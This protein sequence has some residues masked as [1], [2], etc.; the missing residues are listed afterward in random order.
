[1]RICDRKNRIRLLRT[2]V[3]LGWPFTHV[4][5]VWL[6]MAYSVSDKFDNRLADKRRRHLYTHT[7]KIC[8]ATAPYQLACFILLLGRVY[9]RPDDWKRIKR[10]QNTWFRFDLVRFS[11]FRFFF[12]IVHRKEGT[13]KQNTP[14]FPFVLWAFYCS[15]VQTYSTIKRYSE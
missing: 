3:Q 15:V 14:P 7:T 13:E 1:M 10:F 12:P 11:N 4:K 6:C 5:H 8:P 9:E 2:V